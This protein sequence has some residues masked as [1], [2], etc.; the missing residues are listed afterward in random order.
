MNIRTM[1]RAG[2]KVDEGCVD[3]PVTLPVVKSTSGHDL[4][5]LTGS[6]GGGGGAA[7]D[8]WSP[9]ASPGSPLDSD[10][11]LDDL[12]PELL[13]AE[14]TADLDKSVTSE[15]SSRVDQQTPA[16]QLT[17]KVCTSTIDCV[18]I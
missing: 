14:S 6:A 2:G 5:C 9:T 11:A 16:K 18:V 17:G 10:E 15:T 3:D 13:C 7:S 12:P 8:E 1:I 4:D